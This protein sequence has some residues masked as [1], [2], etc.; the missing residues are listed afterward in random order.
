MLKNTTIKARLAFV[1][2]MLSMLMLAIGLSGLNNL[3][4]AN[5]ALKTV[6]QDRLV[7]VGQLDLVI[8]SVNRSL[9]AI[10]VANGSAPERLPDMIAIVEQ[11]MQSSDAIWKQYTATK[12]D[13]DEIPLA[14]QFEDAHRR[15]LENALKPTLE[16]ARNKDMPALSALITGKLFEEYHHVRTILDKLIKLQIKVGKEEYEKSQKSFAAAQIADLAALG[17]G[18][19]AAAAVGIWLVRS[20]TIPLNYAVRIAQ[21]I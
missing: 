3:S 2:V 5:A 4:N 15:F 11:E 6:Y 14:A 19:A 1:L 13:P 7:A 10:T 8:R 12:L 18:L 21:G 20:I 17:L 16:A 9:I